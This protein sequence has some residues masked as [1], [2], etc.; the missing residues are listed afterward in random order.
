MQ[1]TC[2]RCRHWQRAHPESD[3]G[4]CQRYPPGPSDIEA[5]LESPPR[6]VIL[7]DWPLTIASNYCGEFVSQILPVAYPSPLSAN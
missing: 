2:S 6:L 7:N 4:R 3:V 1:R 5:S